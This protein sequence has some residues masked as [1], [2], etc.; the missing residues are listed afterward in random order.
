MSLQAPSPVVVVVALAANKCDLEQYRVV[1]A[2]EGQAYA[3]E[4]ELAYLE[5]SA[6]TAFNVKELFVE[7]AK[8]LPKS[9]PVPEREAFAVA[10]AQ[11]SK[12]S[13]GCC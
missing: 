11:D 3:R 6:K 2:H 13:G 9:Q 7:I 10:P 4:N 5:T 8:R 1:S 12:K